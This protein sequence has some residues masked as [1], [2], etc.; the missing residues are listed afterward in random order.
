LA[1]KGLHFVEGF[2]HLTLEDVLYSGAIGDRVAVEEDARGCGKV[3]R[4]NGGA[5]VF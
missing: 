5:V 3:E 2:G 4:G 1:V